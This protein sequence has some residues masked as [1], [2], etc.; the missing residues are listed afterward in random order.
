M[1]AASQAGTYALGR[2]GYGPAI[3]GNFVLPA[4]NPF[5]CQ[6]RHCRD[7]CDSTCLQVGFDL[8]DNWSVGEGAAVIVEPI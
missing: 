1:T 8:F 5:R 3:P 7:K 2:R 6:I 4:P